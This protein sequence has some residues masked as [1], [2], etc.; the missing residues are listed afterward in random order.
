MELANKKIEG[1][2][3]YV[4]GI[5]KDY[6]V[7]N[8][9]YCGIVVFS[10]E[11]SFV[12]TI[13]IDED[14][15]IYQLFSSP[16]NNYL[17]VQDIENEKLY[18]ID[19]ETMNVVRIEWDII[20]I[21]YY[22]VQN[23]CF[24]VHSKNSSYQFKYQK[25]VLQSREE[26]SLDSEIVLTNNQKDIVSMDDQKEVIYKDHVIDRFEESIGEY[27]LGENSIYKFSETELFI[28]DKKE[29]KMILEV[30][31]EQAIRSIA[32][33]KQTIYVLLNNKSDANESEIKQLHLL[34]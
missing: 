3:V 13:E 20:M 31:K 21:N 12:K 6:L 25:L 2:D 15:V 7:I 10:K 14:L 30:K 24:N 32:I 4:M 34:N 9:N 11:L 28:Y 27:K 8:S 23:E 18:S 22:D 29:W 1:N 19:L 17:V 5:T 33:S 16:I 26:L